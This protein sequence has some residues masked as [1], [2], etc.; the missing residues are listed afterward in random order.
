MKKSFISLVVSLF[1]ISFSV[2]L[3]LILRQFI[4]IPRDLAIIVFVGVTLLCGYSVYFAHCPEK[5]EDKGVQVKSTEY[6]A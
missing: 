4:H 6:F 2:A 1:V 3:Y 5:K